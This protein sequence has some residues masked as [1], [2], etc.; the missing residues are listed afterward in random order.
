MV[1]EVALRGKEQTQPG[2]RPN[3]SQ[4][5]LAAKKQKQLGRTPKNF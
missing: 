4:V 2:K 3:D 1:C 5:M